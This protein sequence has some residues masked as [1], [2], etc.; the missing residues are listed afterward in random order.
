MCG[1]W[2]MNL[3]ELWA[4]MDYAYYEYKGRNEPYRPGVPR[5][6]L[7][8]GYKR[9]EYGNK[10]ESGYAEV[11][12]LDNET[13]E[14]KTRTDGSHVVREVRARDIAMRWNEYEEER[15]HR[16][17][18]R[19]RLAQEQQDREAEESRMK[20]LITDKLV[21]RYG[22]PRE[23]IYNVTATGVHI[24]RAALEKELGLANG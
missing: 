14:P 15:D 5:V 18:Q 4:G 10:R 24:S 3:N 23:L 9:R 12:F 2:T 7:I 22:I 1:G 11:M 6:K 13:G 19:E 17:A 8:R 16:E 21:E 20:S